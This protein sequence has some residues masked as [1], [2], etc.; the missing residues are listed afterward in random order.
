MA[1]SKDTHPENPNPE[2]SETVQERYEEL[3]NS[4]LEQEPKTDS[5][6]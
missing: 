2:Y 4:L 3:F 1:D 5:D 6:A